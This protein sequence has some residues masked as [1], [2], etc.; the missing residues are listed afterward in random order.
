M[1]DPLCGGNGLDLKILMSWG[2]GGGW[3]MV[4]LCCEKGVCGRYIRGGMKVESWGLEVWMSCMET[5]AFLTKSTEFC[6]VSLPYI[7]ESIYEY[8]NSHRNYYVLERTWQG[9]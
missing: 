7:K 6:S 3:Q 1:L 5:H 4:D 9:L 8:K 2:G